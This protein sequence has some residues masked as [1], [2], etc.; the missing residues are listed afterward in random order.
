MK[1]YPDALA[2]PVRKTIT[3]I[4]GLGD[5]EDFYLAGGTA[6]SL[7][8]GHRESVD[9]VFF[10]GNN[11]LGFAERKELLGQLSGWKGFQ[12]EEERQGTLHVIVS[13]TSVSFFHYAYPL[14]HD[15]AKHQGIR[16]ASLEDI[17]LMKLAAL[18]GRGSRKDFIDLFFLAENG[19][20]PKRLLALASKKFKD[21]RDFSVRVMKAA[22]YFEDAEKE[23]IPKMHKK[24]SWDTLKDYFKNAAREIMLNHG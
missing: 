11:T 16:I 3:E 18:A 5:I 10:S 15:A 12:L 19:F 22:V 8:L 7:M 14:L 23:P 6:L 2:V 4:Q 1:F 24:F 21:Q 13:E 20:S 17:G 9:L